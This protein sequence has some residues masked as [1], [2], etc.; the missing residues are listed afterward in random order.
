M[1][2]S[3]LSNISSSSS[4]SS[5]NVHC[6][7]VSNW[8]LVVTAQCTVVTPEDGRVHVTDRQTDGHTDG[9]GRSMNA[10]GGGSVAGGNS[11]Q[12]LG[13]SVTFCSNAAAVLPLSAAVRHLPIL[14]S[15]QVL[16]LLYTAL[17]KHKM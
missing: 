3:E 5:K 4:S 8:Y 14:H 16:R 9:R 13:A 12:H 15:H 10:G 11:E 1:H 17:F 7:E 2:R 6:R